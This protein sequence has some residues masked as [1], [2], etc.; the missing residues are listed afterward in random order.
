MWALNAQSRWQSWRLLENT[1]GWSVCFTWYSFE[2]SAISRE[3]FRFVP[4]IVLTS[5]CLFCDQEKLLKTLISL[6][7][8]T[9]WSLKEIKW[10]WYSD[11]CYYEVNRVYLWIIFDVLT[12]SWAHLNVLRYIIYFCNCW[13]RRANT[14]SMG[15][16]ASFSIL[17][18][19]KQ[20][21][22]IPTLHQQYNYHQLLHQSSWRLIVSLRHTFQCNKLPCFQSFFNPCCLG[23]HKWKHGRNK[24]TNKQTG[25]L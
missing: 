23:A 8:R 17:C 2:F 4:C 20:C 6:Q 1:A 9:W 10:S 7:I 16:C 12:K 21:V 11:L 13:R 3:I 22:H 5:F 15:I 19:Y 25:R 14:Y 24:Q 18:S